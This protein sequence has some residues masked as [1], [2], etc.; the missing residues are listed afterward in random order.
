MPASSTHSAGATV[1]ACAP[2]L[3]H[4]R[5]RR[6]A[7][8]EEQRESDYQSTN[9]PQLHASASS[10]TRYPSDAGLERRILS[11]AR[12]RFLSF[13]RGIWYAP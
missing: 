3:A 11:R 9:D 5:A 2:N 1:A 13:P 8:A 10:Y 6:L 4:D 12:M 7:A